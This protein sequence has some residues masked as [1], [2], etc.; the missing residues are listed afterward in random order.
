[1]PIV[2]I[3]ECRNAKMIKQTPSHDL[4]NL[5]QI[6]FYI[7][8]REV[9]ALMK[10]S[11]SDYI[12]E[13]TVD[14][15][16]TISLLKPNKLHGTTSI[17]N[18]DVVTIFGI[19]SGTEISTVG[20]AFPQILINNCIF[21][22]PFHVIE[23]D[24]NLESDG[25][26]GN[27]FLIKYG[28]SINYSNYTIQFHL[29]SSEIP[30]V[31]D[32]II[33]NP[34]KPPNGS[35]NDQEQELFNTGEMVREPNFE[36]E[37]QTTDEDMND[38]CK[39]NK[40]NEL[41]NCHAGPKSKQGTRSVDNKESQCNLIN[42]PVRNLGHIDLTEI[43]GMNDTLNKVFSAGSYHATP[44]VADIFDTLNLSHCSTEER[45]E[46]LK[47]CEKF[48]E[49]FYLEGDPLKHTDVIR[50][51]IEL[52]PGTTPIFTRQYRIPESQKGE[53]QRQLDDLESRGVI[54]KSNSPWN[55]PLL[56]VPK[57][58]SEK[59]EKKFRLV[60]DYRK[61]NMVTQPLSYPIPLVDE[62]IDQMQ[63]AKIF[64]TLD[65]QGAFHQIPMHPRCKEYTAFSTSWDKYHFNSCPF[66]LVGSP[67]TWLRAIH[68][69]LKGIIG[70]DVY[71]YMDDIIIYS[72]TLG[73]H[74]KTLE[75]VI[76]RLIQHNLKLNIEKSLFMHSQVANLG[77]II[78]RDGIKVDP[79][80]TDCVS[81]FPRPSSVVEVQRFLGM[82]NYYRRYVPNYAKIAKPLYIICKKDIPFIWNTGSE[83]A[84]NQLKKMLVTS[85]VLIYPN[86]NETFIVT[87][88][89]SDY[90]IGAVISQGNIPYDK[91]IQ[92]FSKTLAEAQTRYST[93]EKE[94]LAIVSAL[95]NFR[96]YL[97]GR[98]FLIITDHKPL[99][100]LFDT[101]N[102]NNRLH[103]WRLNLMEFNFKI[104][105][106]Q[107]VQNV[108][109]DALSRIKNEDGGTKGKILKAFTR[110]QR[111]SQANDTK[112]K[113][114]IY[115]G[116]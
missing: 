88:D 101:K 17:S 92:Y 4:F 110:G 60:I 37:T 1:M 107:G 73:E 36:Q 103:R 57:K 8:N 15:G 65:L 71:V 64:T 108:V 26:L 82:C 93:I 115:C 61:L 70:F 99:T 14:T 2:R 21:S 34:P 111:A 100:F 46:M 49:V 30:Y 59:G 47:L 27:D 83:D 113:Q 78:S 13:L 25:I 19:S 85:P 54:E 39:N 74:I 106:K 29:P 10:F 66:G 109:A 116:E 31:K 96:H 75:A 97:Y 53:I 72:K 77:H 79:K 45:N 11:I 68:T 3:R 18:K 58:D 35:N 69:V 55:S 16:A 89:A 104:T 22:H 38:A 40:G 102:V 24:I 90:A 105:H 95:E 91:P 86:F 67:Y 23:G 114:S 62:I 44:R 51:K 9:R 63:G 81:K 52:K 12:L 41:V 112:K 6:N 20:R 98:E 33:R 94:L 48:S 28:A 50:H 5:T 76:K 32:P 87:T 7:I 84:F 80:K 43:N 56:L 42:F